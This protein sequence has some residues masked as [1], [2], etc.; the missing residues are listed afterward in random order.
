MGKL[1]GRAMN[2]RD[3][4]AQVLKPPDHE[5]T[6]PT[7]APFVSFV[8]PDPTPSSRIEPVADA[9]ELEAEAR[10]ARALS[11]LEAHPDTARACFAASAW[12]SSVRL[13]GTRAANGR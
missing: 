7:E 8:S 4:A 13:S 2:W 12:L 10:M 1:R 9:G 6:K 3:R 5:P 11:Y